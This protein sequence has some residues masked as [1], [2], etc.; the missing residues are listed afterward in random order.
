MPKG[1]DIPLKDKVLHFGYFFGGAG[2]FSAALYL[3]LKKPT[4]W[5]ILISL[6]LIV[7]G[8]TGA[9]DEWHQSQ[10]P[11]RYGNDLADW[12]ADILGTLVGALVFKRLH[13]LFDA[14]KPSTN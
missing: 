14:S 5:I 3:S 10:V 1:L 11:G 6:N 12:T 13:F 7:L 2:L 9:L 4:N 8:A